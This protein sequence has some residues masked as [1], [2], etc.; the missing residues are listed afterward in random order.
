MGIDAIANPYRMCDWLF[1]G[2]NEIM[3][4]VCGVYN[5][6]ESY[7][8][9][10]RTRGGNRIFCGETILWERM[11]DLGLESHKLFPGQ[12]GDSLALIRDKESSK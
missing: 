10:L 7:I 12:R 6:L 2:E 5:H 4:G 11:T 9:T 3:N 1:Y 8:P